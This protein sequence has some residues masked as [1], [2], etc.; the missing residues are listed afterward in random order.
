M[1]RLSVWNA[2][3]LSLPFFALVILFMGMKK[4]MAKRM[5]DMTG[6]TKFRESDYKP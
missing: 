6:Y 1:F 3:I 2:W 4:D 5:S